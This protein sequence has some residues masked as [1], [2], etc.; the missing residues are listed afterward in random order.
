VLTAL[1]VGLYLFARPEGRDV[2]W[3]ISTKPAIGETEEP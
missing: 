3:D 1:T 2:F